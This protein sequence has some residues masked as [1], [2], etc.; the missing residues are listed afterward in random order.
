M[1]PPLRPIT[2]DELPKPTTP[3]LTLAQPELR[4][5]QLWIPGAEAELWLPSDDE[6]AELTDPELEE[7]GMLIEQER[8]AGE[9]ELRLQPKQML[10]WLVAQMVDEL[11]YGGAAGGGKT[12][13]LIEY[14]AAQMEA[15]RHNRGVIFRRVSPSLSRTVIPRAKV[16]LAGRASWNGQ[17][18]T[19]TFPN[20]SVLEMAHL[21]YADSV[22]QH[23]GTEYGVIAFEE[24][25]EFLLSQYE[26]LIQRLRAPAPGIRPHAVS[27]TN[28]GGVGHRWV[29]RRFIRPKLDEDV[30]DGEEPPR[31]FRPWRPRFDPEIHDRENPPLIRLFVPA[32]LDDNPALVER[33]PAY[34]SRLRAQSDRGLRLAMEKGDWDAIDAVE[35]AKWKQSWLD[36]GRMTPQF[37]KRH[38]PAARRALAVDPADGDGGD[39]YGLWLGYRA[40]TGE[41]LTEGSWALN[42]MS[43]QEMA[44]F[45]VN[46]YNETG[47]DVLVVE[48]NH[49]GKWLTAVLLG[50]D[51]YANI[52]TVWASENK[53]TRAE[54]VAA[55]F[56]PET[57]LRP[58]DLKYLA[59]LIGHH[60]ELEEEL[61]TTAFEAG[62]VSP[63]R[64]D[65]LVW[66]HTELAGIGTRAGRRTEL[67]DK[68]L[69]GRR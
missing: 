8:T 17:E 50:V 68:R 48:R 2:V 38:R 40:T 21:Q 60:P 65:A 20:G 18:H 30:T 34:R 57:E 42:G 37:A 67:S 12:F 64:L 35:G 32:T 9:T 31:P 25:T 45:T 62:E 43:V 69:D 11:L 3:G 7:L 13:F 52:Q 47:C 26:A 54:P 66:G 63:N 24:I 36:D 39:E 53:K 5:P 61:T 59:R 22:T 44:R 33:D 49:G 15:H 55:L 56:E 6:L 16:A 10:A 23:Q 58:P 41:I 51:R 4:T 14:V 27:T 19:F 46:L 28:P 1:P 29:K